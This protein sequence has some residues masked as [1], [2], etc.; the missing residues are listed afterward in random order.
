G[1]SRGSSSAGGTAAGAAEVPG[2]R[3][4]LILL[5]SWVSV[6]RVMLSAS[7]SG[8]LPIWPG[9]SGEGRPAPSRP[10]HGAAARW[11]RLVS[12]GL[13]RGDR[14]ADLH[15]LVVATAGGV[16]H[17][18]PGDHLVAVQPDPR[19]EHRADVGQ[20]VAREAPVGQLAGHVPGV[21]GQTGDQL[22]ALPLALILGLLSDLVGGVGQLVTLD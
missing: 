14:P 15:D 2:T 9:S 10:P 16:R 13:V 6:G 19:L 4:S 8:R 17:E 22:G 12:G 21:G 18:P 5:T 1:R 3:V 11:F 20:L 7:L